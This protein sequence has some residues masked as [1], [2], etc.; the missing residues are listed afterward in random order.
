MGMQS[1]F[2]RIVATVAPGEAPDAARRFWS[3]VETLAHVR[4]QAE[5]AR[6]GAGRHFRRIER[7]LAPHL[8]PA[9]A[10]AL[11]A[12]FDRVMEA[13]TPKEVPWRR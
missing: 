10:A 5:N 2:R 13:S 3:M 12:L 11:A 1:E 6:T 9:D 4:R 7:D 8:A